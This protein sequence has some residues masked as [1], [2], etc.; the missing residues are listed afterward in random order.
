MP[1]PPITTAIPE[2]SFDIDSPSDS[3]SLLFLTNPD[4]LP[5]VDLD[6]DLD[7]ETPI[8]EEDE[9]LK[10]NKFIVEN[11]NRVLQVCIHKYLCSLTRFKAS[12]FEGL[13]IC[14]CFISYRILL[15]DREDHSYKDAHPK[16]ENPFRFYLL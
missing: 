10:D 3:A 9:A 11:R 13:I 2:V 5:D 7:E 4:L 1:P 6:Q 16:L 8:L 15:D 12:H 14:I